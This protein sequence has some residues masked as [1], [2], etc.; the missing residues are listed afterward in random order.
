MFP[1]VKLTVKDVI[2]SWAGLR[3]LIYEDGKSASELSRKDEII[4]SPSGLLSIAGGKLTGYRLM[5]KKVADI[6]A[7]DLLSEGK[8]LK[9]QPRMTIISVAGSLSLRKT[10]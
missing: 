1:D 8:H 2:S 4:V 9:P 10:C 7:R 5:A 6:A 3:P